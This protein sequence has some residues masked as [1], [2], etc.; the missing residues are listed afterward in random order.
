MGEPNPAV[1]LPPPGGKKDF[2]SSASLKRAEL[3]RFPRFHAHEAAAQLYLKGFLTK[4]GIGRKNEATGTVNL[5]E[6]GIL[7]VTHR[8]HANDT[9]VQVRVEIEKYKDVI[10]VDGIVRWCFQ[11][12]RD[13]AAFYTGIEFIDLPPAQA[14]LIA[15]MRAWFT[16]PEYKQKNAT[17][18]RLA[19]PDLHK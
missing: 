17:R 10:E 13:A 3:R 8:K 11:S 5:S 7:V 19:P 1:P 15:K 4:I 14:A 12:A 16:S 18:R 6:G 2:T 9:K